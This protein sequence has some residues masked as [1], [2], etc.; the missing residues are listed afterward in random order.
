M[1]QSLFF[2][3]VKRRNHTPKRQRVQG[4]CPHVELLELRDMPSAGLPNLAMLPVG[5]PPVPM[6][7][8]NPLVRGNNAPPGPDGSLALEPTGTFARMGSNNTAP[9]ADVSFAAPM[10]G[11]R[12]TALTNPF[13]LN[14]TEDVQAGGGDERRVLA[15]LDDATTAVSDIPPA[16][17]PAIASELV[18]AVGL[19]FDAVG[20]LLNEPVSPGNSS[21]V[22]PAPSDRSPHESHPFADVPS[23]DDPEREKTNESQ[24]AAPTAL[25]R[26]EALRR[27]LVQEREAEHTEAATSLLSAAMVAAYFLPTAVYRKHRPARRKL[28]GE[29]E[30]RIASDR[31]TSLL[32]PA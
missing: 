28:E 32:S 11:N 20:V 19:P 29:S 3:W 24:T 13:N 16:A 5:G 12:P 7:A 6:V 4:V 10:T 23:T 15:A 26:P 17:E 1:I 8:S 9:G 14:V 2:R 30:L 31:S 21:D 27:W 22:V 18:P 25:A